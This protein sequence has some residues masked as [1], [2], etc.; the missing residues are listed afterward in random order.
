MIVGG[1]AGTLDDAVRVTRDIDVV[2]W[3]QEQN[4]GRICEFLRAV[5]GHSVTGPA[6][7][8]AEIT[9]EV[10]TEREVM[11][12]STQFGRIDTL[13][14]IPDADGLPV[15]YDQLLSRALSVRVGG[16][17]VAVGGLDDVI[18]SKEWSGRRKDAEALPELRRLRDAEREASAG[19]N[20]NR[21][22]V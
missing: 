15:S 22:G 16:L 19:D 1:Y 9:P 10:L 14:G 21:P 18:T 8:G 12:W 5:D 7:A 17:D 2:P 3:W 6:C 11:N 20:D 13:V 4:L